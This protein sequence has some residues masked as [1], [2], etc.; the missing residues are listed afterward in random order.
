MTD[1]SK[2]IIGIVIVG[3]TLC[4][5][6]FISATL[7]TNFSAPGTTGSATNESIAK[8][9]T[10]G[11]TLFASGLLD[12]RCGSITAASNGTGGEA[13]GLTN[14]TQVGCVVHNATDLSPYGSTILIT[15]PYS[16]TES[17]ASSNASGSLVTALA[18]GSAWITILVVVGFAVIVLGM[19]SS[20][21]G[22]TAGGAMGRE[23]EVGYTY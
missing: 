10:A 18:G 7:Q 1:M 13:I 5:G 4:I 15:Y 2:F 23:G 3:I 21:L 19:L 6:I 22:R 16:Y 20:G 12:G 8:P 14:F 9:T 11:I 17:T